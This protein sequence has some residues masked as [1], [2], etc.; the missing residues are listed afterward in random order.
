MDEESG[1]M[2]PKH[3]LTK[4]K[5]AVK[6]EPGKNYAS[7]REA[8]IDSTERMMEKVGPE[9]K[10]FDPLVSIWVENFQGTGLKPLKE[11]NRKQM[12]MSGLVQ[13]ETPEEK[14]MM[15]RIFLYSIF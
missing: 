4:K 9:S 7:Q 6:I 11:F 10:Y 13:P 2:I 3:D 14:Q 5:F 15:Y 8:T 1:V 12:V